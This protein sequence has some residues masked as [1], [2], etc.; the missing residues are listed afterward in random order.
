VSREEIKQRFL[1]YV[2]F[3]S[4]VLIAGAFLR[5][6]LLYGN[7]PKKGPSMRVK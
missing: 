3:N 4:N 5:K 7:P 1:S 6:I 2:K